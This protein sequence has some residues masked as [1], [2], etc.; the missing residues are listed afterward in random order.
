[1]FDEQDAQVRKQSTFGTSNRDGYFGIDYFSGGEIVFASNEGASG[2]FNLWRVNPNDNQRRQLTIGSGSRNENPSISPDDKFIY[3]ASNRGGK[4]HSW[5]IEP[6]GENPQQITFGENSDETFPNISPDGK[7]LYFIRKNAKS[8]AVWRKTLSD[9]AEE[10]IT[11]EKQFAPTNIL[12]L[13]PDGKYLGFHNLSGQ[14]EGER[15]NY[16]IAVI[17]TANPPAVKFFNIGG[18]K[19]EIF[20]TADSTAFDY[21]V[22]PKGRD[23]IR[24]LY[25]DE[26]IEMQIVRTFP[27][28]VIFFIA[29]SPD[30]KTIAV[31]YGQQLLDAVMLTNLE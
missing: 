21:I 9:N 25:L 18:A 10:K 13:S 8:S 19:V 5:R 27:N 31:A 20:W 24:R 30:G 28:E 14:I 23:E 7:Y 6:H 29:H 16:Q 1:M 11:D 3:F 17:E 15:Q 2:D 22:H 26:K 4:S 12:A